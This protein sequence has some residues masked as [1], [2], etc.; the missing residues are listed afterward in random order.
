[1]DPQRADATFE[2]R[3]DDVRIRESTRRRDALFGD[4]PEPGQVASIAGVFELAI[5]GH[6]RR[7]AGLACAHR[8]ALA[9]DRERGGASAPD[10][11]GDER[12]VIDRVD[13]LGALRAVIDAH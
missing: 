13:G 1:D 10:V 5:A 4:V 11:A 6:A 12:E 9:G 3:L 7:E 2:R 8:I